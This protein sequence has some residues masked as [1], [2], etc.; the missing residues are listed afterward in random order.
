MVTLATNGNDPER[1]KALG[2]KTWIVSESQATPEQMEHYKDLRHRLTIN[3]HTHKK[4]PTAPHN[5]VLPAACCTNVSPWGEPQAT[6]E[7]VKG[8]V[9]N[10]PDCYAHLEYVPVNDDICC[11]F[12]D[13]FVTKFMNKSYDKEICRWCLG[14]GRVWAQ[15]P[16]NVN[17]QNYKN[18]AQN[19]RWNE[20]HT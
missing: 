18:A 12:E 1:I 14:N 5:D 16:D 15:T 11:D 13:D 8:K 10:C 6:F 2:L 3:G 19:T 9:Y 17:L 7:Y 20:N 4:M